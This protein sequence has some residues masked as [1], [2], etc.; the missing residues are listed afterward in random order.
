MRDLAVMR[1]AARADT[2]GIGSQRQTSSDSGAESV[3]GHTLP[4]PEP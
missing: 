3:T 1:N 2:P 4:G